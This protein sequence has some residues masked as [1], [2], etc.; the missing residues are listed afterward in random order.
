M[1]GGNPHEAAALLREAISKDPYEAANYLN[2]ANIYE[3]ALDFE[4]DEEKAYLFHEYS[5]DPVS[6]THL[7]VYKRQVCN[8]LAPIFSV[9]SL[10]SLAMAAISSTASDVNTSSM[11][12]V[13]RSAIYCL[14]KAF[15]G[16]QRIR[17]KSSLV[18]PVSYTHLSDSPS[19]WCRLISPRLR[20]LI[21]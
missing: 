1:E 17:L 4:E 13:A 9:S 7:D 16:S 19:L 8:R 6:Y 20:M 5:L 18:R 2:L 15:S 3:Q 11:P 14:I 12:S 21:S 10:T